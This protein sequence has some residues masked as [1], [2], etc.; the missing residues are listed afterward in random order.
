MPYRILRLL[1]LCL[2][3]AT[4]V[5]AQ[6]TP[7]LVVAWVDNGDVWVWR[8]KDN[9]FTKYTAG[10]ASQPYISPDGRYIAFTTDSPSGLWLITPDSPTPIEVVPNSTLAENDPQFMYINN[11]LWGHNNILYFSTFFSSQAASAR[12]IDFWSVDALNQTYK[13]V[14]G[15]GEGGVFTLSPNGEYIAFI[16]PGI[17]DDLDATLRIMDAASLS[18]VNTFNYPAVSSASNTEFIPHVSW[19]TDS[20]SLKVGIPDKDLV[21]ADDT[22]L[23]TLWQFGIDGSQTQLN[24]LQASFFTVPQWSDDGAYMFYMRHKGA[25]SENLYE[26]MIAEGDGSN[27]VVY[28]TGTSGTLGLPQWIPDSHQFIFP[29]YQAGEL[30]IGQPAKPETPFTNANFIVNFISSSIYLYS[31]GTPDNYTLYYGD[32]NSLSSTPIARLPVPSPF[33]YDAVLIP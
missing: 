19:Q 1:I 6:T 24:T 26:L 30:W 23:T 8:A 2:F 14:F 17:Y 21:Y 15:V 16:Q 11:V 22:A 3:T 7:N 5:H 29:Q 20:Q 18:V 9:T 31:S 13:Q 4:V 27:P 12:F 10:S 28:I 32:L 25:I 33:G